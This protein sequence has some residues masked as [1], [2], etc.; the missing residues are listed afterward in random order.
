MLLS[1]SD[2]G[3]SAWRRSGA[4]LDPADRG[5]ARRPAVR[6]RAQAKQVRRRHDRH[7]RHHSG[8]CRRRSRADVPIGA[9]K[10]VEGEGELDRTIHVK[11][12][13]DLRALDF[14]QVLTE[15]AADRAPRPRRDRNPPVVARLS[16]RTRRR[17]PA[18]HDD[19]AAGDLRRPRRPVA[20]ARRRD[21][22]ALRV[23]RRRELRLRVGLFMDTLLAADVGL[24]SLVLL[25]VGYGAGRLRELATRHALVPVAVG[26]AATAAAAIGFSVL[27][28]LLGVDAPVSFL[29]VRQ[30]LMTIVL[31]T[32]LAMPVYLAAA[33]SSRVP[34][35]RPAPA[36]A[37]RVHDRRPEPAQP[38]LASQMPPPIE[39]RRPPITP[40]L[41][42]RVAVLGG[43]AFVLFAIIFFRLWFLQVLTGD[44]YVVQARENRIRKVKIEA[45]AA[46]SSTATAGRSSRPAP[47]PWSSS[48]PTTMPERGARGGRDLPQGARRRPRAAAGRRA[49]PARRST[50]AARRGRRVRRRKRRVPSS[51]HA[52]AAPTGCRSPIPPGEPSCAR[53]TSGSAGDRDGAGDD[54]QRVVQGIADQPSA[55]VTIKTDVPSARSTTCSSTARS[56]PGV[57]V[58]KKYLR[59]YPYKTLGAQLFG[60]LRE[61]SPDEV[62]ES[63]PRRQPGTRIGKDGIE[64]SYDN[65]LRGT[66]GSRA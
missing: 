25:C 64:E 17:D 6:P 54:P 1:D 59:H 21:R 20:A 40:Q 42:V 14:V 55:N 2:F 8:A 56:F 7:G 65:Y 45:R 36:Q 4:R 47:R 62:G 30:I 57:V 9:V 33:A 5:L 48:L 50:P 60:T 31:N 38:R 66:D 11:P 18:A 28:F 39:D 12:F 63:A 26:A 44:D 15:P 58:E 61:I 37:P 49:G 24:T 3:V 10:R 43:F 22:A 27:Q 19:L 23:D 35:R 51:A 32:L 13:A 53:S 46:T 34:A 16:C 41:A 29:L 52:R